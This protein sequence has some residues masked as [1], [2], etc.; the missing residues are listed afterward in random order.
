MKLLITALIFSLIISCSSGSGSVAGG[1]EEGNNSISLVGTVF[2]NDNNK[3]DGDTAILTSI[4]LEDSAQYL[5]KRVTR[6]GEYR[7][8]SLPK[9]SYKLTLKSL[10]GTLFYS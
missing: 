5:E 2:T 1:I 6:D 7:F 4:T 9:G 8:D 3:S 10:S